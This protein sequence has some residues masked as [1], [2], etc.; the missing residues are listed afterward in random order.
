MFKDDQGYYVMD[1][2]ALP[3]EK[4]IVLA[5]GTRFEVLSV[6]QSVDSD[7]LPLNIITLKNMNYDGFVK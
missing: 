6:E 5:D 2:S 1:M 3:Q 7:G 4:E